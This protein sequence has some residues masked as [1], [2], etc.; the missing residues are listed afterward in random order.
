M[1]K[2]TAQ[3][4]V[5]RVVTTTFLAALIATTSGCSFTPPLPATPSPGPRAYSSAS[6]RPSYYDRYR[7]EQHRR[8]VEK[9]LRD[10][11]RNTQRK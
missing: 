8:K 5:V 10:I 11:K 2:P 1:I 9:E 4:V 7:E 3:P 6:D